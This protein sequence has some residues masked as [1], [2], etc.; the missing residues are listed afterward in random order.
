MEENGED[1]A[2]CM[3]KVACRTFDVLP[4]PEKI[5]VF[6]Y[7]CRDCGMRVS[8]YGWEDA[9]TMFWLRAEKVTVRRLVQRRTNG[10]TLT[11]S[12]RLMIGHSPFGDGS[13]HNF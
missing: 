9:R 10:E 3:H 12:E 6:G 7:G 1:P 5:A 4:G 8:A 2:L 11:E 13:S